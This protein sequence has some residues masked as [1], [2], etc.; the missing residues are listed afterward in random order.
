MNQ[1][2][3][4]DSTEALLQVIRA[5]ERPAGAP[6]SLTDPA[7][8]ARK[9][10]KVRR[11][12][13]TLAERLGLA[14]LGK[15]SVLGVDI[16]EDCLAVVKM[17]RSEAGR[18]QDAVRFPYAPGAGPGTPAFPAFLGACLRRFNG[19]LSS[20]ELWTV[21]RS[22]DFDLMPVLIPR[23]P[24]RK[25][26]ETAYWKLQK[27]RKFSDAEHVLDLRVQGQVSDKGLD[28]IEVLTCLARAEEV[29]A[30]ARVFAEAGLTLAGITAIPG[31]LQ[32]VLRA[33]SAYLTED[34]TAT[35]H[36]DA[37][38]S[39][40][41]ITAGR[42][43]LFS[44]TI[45]SGANSMAEA[46]MEHWAGRPGSGP[47]DLQAARCLMSSRLLDLPLADGVADLPVSAD[48]VFE[49]VSPA[50]ERLARQAERTLDYFLAN[51]GTR[52][53]RLVL[54]GP[55]FASP[56]VRG[57][58]AGQ[59]GLAEEIFDPLASRGDL[60]RFG[61]EGEQ[62]RM[63]Q[64]LAAS[65]G[66]SDSG[67][68][69][70]LLVNYR[71]R[72]ENRRRA[73]LNDAV[74]AAA[75]VLVAAAAGFYLWT[76]SQAASGRQEY[77]HLEAQAA[78]FNPRLDQARLLALAGEVGRQRADIRESGER[79]EALAILSELAGLM[80]GNVRVLNLTLDLGRMADAK[81]PA[82]APAAAA[83]PAPVKA[84]AGN[85]ARLLVLDAVILG[86]PGEF[87][88]T[89]SRFLISL[90]ASP[91]FGTPVIHSSGVQDFVPEGKVLHVVL[92]IALA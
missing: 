76:E 50:L 58:V 34:L 26:E 21:L 57:F 67:S 15:G 12:R 45:K 70:N 24:A 47:M 17:G 66:L 30:L 88:R 38:F 53:E 62:D 10:R 89:L 29:Q 78:A 79:L 46:L 40:I 41:T 74:V 14:R 55:L 92:H 35:I 1:R 61:L 73:R 44:R 6:L 9:P 5:G 18:V 43:I 80:P 77:Q 68:T 32:N 16:R 75:A 49:I 11:P 82:G 25:I 81:A 85:P 42:R 64:A 91:L 19:A 22:G 23:V 90:D 13:R 52:V 3:K 28:K 83:A 87:D 37:S 2:D 33:S 36:V 65:L 8:P 54:A 20:C 31:A 71:R 59:L 84:G 72:A 7:E 60:T 63:D 86:D 69:L 48:Q 39:C 51:Q 4:I 27:E 56:R